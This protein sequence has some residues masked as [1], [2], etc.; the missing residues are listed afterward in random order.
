MGKSKAPH[1]AATP[2]PVAP[3]TAGPLLLP[4]ESR[5][6]ATVESVRAEM[7]PGSAAHAKVTISGLLHDGGTRIQAIDQKRTAQGV[8]ITV[9]ASCPVRT[10]AGV[11]LI[12][13]E[14]SVEVDLTGMKPGACRIAANGV[15]TMVTVP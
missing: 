10:S 15:S 11:A 3:N 13:F 9:T 12:P 1:G 4:A 5:P 8:E 7:E 14:R 6:L 2:P